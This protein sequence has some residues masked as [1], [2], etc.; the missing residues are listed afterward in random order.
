MKFNNG[1]LKKIKKTIIGEDTRESDVLYLT[2]QELL[3][4]IFA[5]FQERLHEETT[6]EYLLFPTCF[7]VYL[8]QSDYDKR[9]EAFG[10]TVKGVVNMFYRYI[11]KK[12]QDYPDYKPHATFWR[13]QFLPHKEGMFVEDNGNEIMA[14]QKEPFII[15][16]IYSTNFSEGNFGSENFVATKHD[17]SSLKREQYNVN[18][19]ALL[20]VE[21][22]GGCY[23]VKFDASCTNIVHEIYSDDQTQNSEERAN[24]T[25]TIMG[26]TFFGAREGV[27][28]Y[29]MTSNELH[30]SGKNDERRN[31]SI[32][33]IDS[34]QV[35]S[36]HIQIK[37]F[38]QEDIFKLAAFG[39]VKCNER[40]VP[41]SSGDDIFW[42]NLFHNSDIFIN[43]EININ[44]K[45]NKRQ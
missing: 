8:H 10:H 2:A 9:K 24:A 44:F 22:E 40:T 12:M 42:I 43:N 29:F 37:Y 45:I 33:K 39:S 34:E 23:T 25:L 21:Q 14:K 36:S 17:Q 20:D 1:F 4:D 18:R 38:A 35:L 3:D 41:L 5:I 26:G 15:S 32:L 19:D 31:M 7:Y 11:R 13:V 30:I 16:T 27:T 28:K 6:S